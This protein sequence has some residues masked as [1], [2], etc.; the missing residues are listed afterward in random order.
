[1]CFAKQAPCIDIELISTFIPG[2]EFAIFTPD[3][4]FFRNATTVMPAQ[5]ALLERQTVIRI[6]QK[7][8]HQE[9]YHLV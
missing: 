4:I 5:P 1:M 8:F 7:T 9:Q 2:C 6:T 3:F